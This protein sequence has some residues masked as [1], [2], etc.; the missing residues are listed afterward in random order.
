MGFHLPGFGVALGYKGHIKRVRTVYPR[1][2]SF[3]RY[4]LEVICWYGLGVIF[5]SMFFLDV[6]F[7]LF[8]PVWGW[9]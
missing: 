4:G 5:D 3:F 6:G 1:M 2:G 9:R 8:R 7:A